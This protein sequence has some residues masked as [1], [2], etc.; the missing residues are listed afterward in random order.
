MGRRGYTNDTTAP[1]SDIRRSR[2]QQAPVCR[3]IPLDAD[4]G[5]H[6]DGGSCRVSLDGVVYRNY[7]H[8]SDARILVG[9][10]CYSALPLVCDDSFEQQALVEI[11]TTVTALSG[12]QYNPPY[13]ALTTLQKAGTEDAG[14]I[15]PYDEV[16]TQYSTFPDLVVIGIGYQSA[17]DYVDFFCVPRNSCTQLMLFSSLG[18][19]TVARVDGISKEQYKECITVD[20]YECYN[21]MTRLVETIDCPLT[22]RRREKT[23]SS[24]SIWTALTVVIG[25]T[26]GLVIGWLV[27]L[28]WSHCVTKQQEQ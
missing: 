26:V 25:L 6:P 8:C 19:N 4:G 12:L 22:A 20:G 24:R 17:T 21:Q 3:L 14:Q 23:T 27:Q 2:Y 1:C 11:Q 16:Q 13:W 5:L 7:Y 9:T 15:Y 10:G 18:A 28:F